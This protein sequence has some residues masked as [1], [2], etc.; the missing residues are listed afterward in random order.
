MMV[1]KLRKVW[2]WFEPVVCDVTEDRNECFLVI[3]QW[4]NV[5]YLLGSYVK[6]KDAGSTQ[7]TY[8]WWLGSQNKYSVPVPRS[9][10][11]GGTAIRMAG[12]S[13]SFDRWAV[14]AKRNCKPR[15]PTSILHMQSWS[16]WAA[17]QA[18]KRLRFVHAL[19]NMPTRTKAD[20]FGVAKNTRPIWVHRY[21]RSF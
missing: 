13:L 7:S 2:F 20:F 4:M 18:Q 12:N 21:M 17:M 3:T 1:E 9:P 11:V 8:T 6:L 5:G 16:G 15:T 14:R 19:Q 10:Q